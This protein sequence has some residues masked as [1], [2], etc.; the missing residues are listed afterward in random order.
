M[1]KRL[2]RYGVNRLEEWRKRRGL[3][4]AALA[5]MVGTRGGQIQKLELGE[6]RLT[7]E[8]MQ[9][10]AGALSVDASDLLPAANVSKHTAMLEAPRTVEVEQETPIIYLDGVAYAAVRTEPDPLSTA[11]IPPRKIYALEYLRRITRSPIEMLVALRAHGDAM[12]P[13]ILDSAL[14]LVDRAAALGRAGI[15]A[16]RSGD[17]I[18]VRRVSMNPATQRLD[19]VADNPAYPAARDVDAASLNVIGRVLIISQLIA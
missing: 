19:L 12:A 5:T 7:L 16:F 17:E 3:S 11:P 6:R 2:G 14:L 8:W 1:A 18:E 13:T 4:R 10:L 9:R 15:Y